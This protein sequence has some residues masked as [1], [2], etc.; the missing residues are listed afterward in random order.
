[1]ASLMVTVT[2]SPAWNAV[3]V[4][5]GVPPPS[6]PQGPSFSGNP[7]LSCDIHD[8]GASRMKCA[9]VGADH[10][11]PTAPARAQPSRR[12]VV[13]A[14]KRSVRMQASFSRASA[15]WAHPDAPVLSTFRDATGE[16]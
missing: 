11:T 6:S 15:Y 16:V 8:A 4:P 5:V 14:F 13:L 1:M 12:R 2:V 7:T 10:D 3:T 9:L